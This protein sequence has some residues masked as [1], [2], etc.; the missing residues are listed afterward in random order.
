MDMSIKSL[1]PQIQSW[2]D[3]DDLTRNFHYTRMLPKHPVKL[4]LRIKS[5]LVL[6]GT[7]YLAAVFT[8]LGS[9]NDFSFLETFEGR[10]LGDGTTIEFPETMPFNLAVTGERLALNL[11]QH[12]SSIATWTSKHVELAKSKGIKILDTRKTTPGLRSLEKYAVRVGGGFNHRLGQT[13]TW[14]VKDNHKS[15]LGGM[16]GALKFFEDQGVFYNNIVVEIHSIDELK[17]AI[18]LGVQHVMLDNFSPEKIKE[19]VELKKPGMTFEASGGL[20]LNTIPQY[21][22]TGV[23]AL[24][25]GSLTYSA[26]RVDLSLKFRSV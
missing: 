25:L 21:L 22:I 26:P 17:E 19:A 7:D 13:D 11:V 20:N 9:H 10:E 15:S 12:A 8:Q 6:A 24:S 5:P 18:S 2:L 1:L 4:V 3:E 16:K 14:M 23:D